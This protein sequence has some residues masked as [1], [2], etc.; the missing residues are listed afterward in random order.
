MNKISQTKYQ[1]K[2]LHYSKTVILP[3]SSLDLQN[4]LRDRD[5]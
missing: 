4:C 1:I 3:Q 2:A 5:I